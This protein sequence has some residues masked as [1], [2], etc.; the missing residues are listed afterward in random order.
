MSYPNSI[1]FSNL[2]AEMARKGITIQNLANELEIS[3]QTA[4]H[5][6]SGKAPLYL[7]EAIKINK[8]FFPETTVDYLFQEL[9]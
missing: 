2:R 4:S 3:R 6:F 8:R 1:V 5:K 7:D 9:T